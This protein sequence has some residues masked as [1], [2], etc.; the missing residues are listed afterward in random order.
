VQIFDFGLAKEL[1]ARDQQDEDG[2][3]ATG[4]TGSRKYMA[5]EV[6]SIFRE[7]FCLQ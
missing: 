5:P 3:E 2:Y 1:K 6:W 4:L 7:R